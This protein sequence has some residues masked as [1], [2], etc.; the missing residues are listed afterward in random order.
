MK[1][2]M[3][4]LRC[5]SAAL[6]VSYL[7]VPMRD[8]WF[9][10]YRWSSTG[11]I[12]WD[13]LCRNAAG[14]CCKGGLDSLWGHGR[15]TGQFLWYNV[16]VDCA[17]M[18][19]LGQINPIYISV[20]SCNDAIVGILFYFIARFYHLFQND[21]ISSSFAWRLRSPKGRWRRC[22]G[23]PTR[24]LLTKVQNALKHYSNVDKRQCS[25]NAILLIQVP[26]V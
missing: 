13:V 7:F 22:S 2:W 23:D 6:N 20:H 9:R 12:A 15:L 8:I 1:S 25:M 19:M 18:K 5:T 10:I 16:P 3:Y 21:K 4:C 24:H 14:K 26:L 11:S 17:H